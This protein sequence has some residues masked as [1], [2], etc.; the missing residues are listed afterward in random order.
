MGDYFGLDR[1]ISIILL[2]IPFT[3]WWCGLITRIKDGHYVAAVIR[4]FFGCEILWI[5]EIILTIINGCN[6]TVWRLIKV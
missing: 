6:V 5:I 1:W 4:I 3:C 2:I